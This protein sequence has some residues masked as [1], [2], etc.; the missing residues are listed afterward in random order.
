MDQISWA[1]FLLLSKKHSQVEKQGP[2]FVGHIYS[3]VSKSNQVKKKGPNF[4]GHF[5][6]ICPKITNLILGSFVKVSLDSQS[7]DDMF[8]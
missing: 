7:F 8:M 3:P 1:T 6:Y 2:N 4:M 5:F